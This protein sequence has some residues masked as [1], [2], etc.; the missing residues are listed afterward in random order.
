[1]LNTIEVFQ[2]KQHRLTGNN[3]VL[4]FESSE[5]KLSQSFFICVIL[6]WHILVGLLVSTF[7]RKCSLCYGNDYDTVI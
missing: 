6:C 1:M 7:I 4:N 3:S 2:G 5:E